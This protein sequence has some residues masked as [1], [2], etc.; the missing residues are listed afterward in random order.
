MLSLIHG[1]ILSA[2]AM[3]I[4]SV[5]F[6]LVPNSERT[7]VVSKTP[8]FQLE[9]E[10]IRITENRSLTTLIEHKRNQSRTKATITRLW[11]IR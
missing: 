2:E 5:Y 9:L 4:F 8:R 6:Q 1:V 3:L 10:W 7:E 11:V